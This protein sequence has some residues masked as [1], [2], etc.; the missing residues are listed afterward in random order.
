MILMPILKSP[1]EERL[2]VIRK[3]DVR[4][5]LDQLIETEEVTIKLLIDSLYDIGTIN[6]INQK[7]SLRPVNGVAKSIATLSKPACRHFALRWF[8]K[9]CPQLIAN[10]LYTK[11]AFKPP[12][13]KAKVAS[14]SVPKPQPAS[15]VPAPQSVALTHVNQVREIQ[16]LRTQVKVLTGVLVGTIAILGGTTA[17]QLYALHLNTTPSTQAEPATSAQW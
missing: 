11:V 10:W 4:L 8:K 1:E 6:L 16:Q 7:V 17:V 14:P 5:L 12:A 3:R 9:N 15:P 2:E 13:P